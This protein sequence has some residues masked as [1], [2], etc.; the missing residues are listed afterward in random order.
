[1]SGEPVSAEAA[2]RILR[3]RTAALDVRDERAFAHAHLAGSGNIPLAELG[4][5]RAELP[6]RDA[7]LLVVADDPAEAARAADELASAGFGDVKYLA[8]PWRGMADVIEG[9]PGARLWR[10]ASFLEE[11]LPV[12]PRGHAL[13]LAAGTGRNAVCLALHDFE[14]EAWD[15]DPEALAR[16]ERLARRE[17]VAI[18]TKV[19]DLES[20]EPPI[21]PGRFE[22]VACFRYL[23]RPLFPLMAR[24]LAPGGHLVYETYR[25]GQERFGKPTRERFLLESGELVRAFA[26]LEILRYEEPDPP[27]GPLTARL[28]ARRR[29]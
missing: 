29:D 9:G 4:E 13:D 17:R 27:G 1:M 3:Q 23:H 24:A 26:G 12:L 18:Q 11:I 22:L 19:C 20:G 16:A 6:P 5:R 7:P 15:I 14:V 10:P 8:T 28:L 25:I 21:P 2:R